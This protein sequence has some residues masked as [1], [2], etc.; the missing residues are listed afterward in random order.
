MTSKRFEALDAFRGLCAISVVVYHMRISNSIAE[1]DFF[2]GSYILVE[3]FFAL[4]GFVLAHSYGFRK[5]L[6]FIPFIK[7]RFFRLYP[8]HFFVFILFLIL[9]LIKL[10][11]YNI[12]GLTFNNVPFTNSFDTAEI[13]PNLLL[14]QAWTPLTDPLSFNYPSWSIS[15]EF[16]LYVFLFL[17][18]LIFKNRRV[19]SW[20]AI[21]LFAFT[22]LLSKSNLLVN[23]ALSGLFCFFGGAFTYSIYKQISNK[24]RINHYAGTLLELILIFS[25]Y[26]IVTSQS[27]HRSI[28]PPFIFFIVIFLFS[29]ESG[30]ISKALMLK[31]P[32]FTGKL[33]YSIYMTHAAIL[34]ILTSISIV[35]EK[36]TGYKT[37]EIINSVRFLDFGSDII[38]NTFILFSLFFVIFISYFSYMHIEIKWQNFYKANNTKLALN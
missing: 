11:A 17:S 7:S 20:L 6:K 38:N 9:E 29:F 14:I 27:E 31:A 15:I 23:S 4:S 36:T 16:Y 13:L 5:D 25:V 26:F 30:A 28:Y 37:N 18:I 10:F 32:Q 34:F 1:L 19:L 2:R 22:L 33:S 21:T 35:L 3:F 24:I 12:G 8:L